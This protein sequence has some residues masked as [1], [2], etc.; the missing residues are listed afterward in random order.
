M[1]YSEKLGY[2]M[3]FFDEYTAI[4]TLDSHEMIVLKQQRLNC[5]VDMNMN[6]Q[7]LVD[8]VDTMYR[9][10][11]GIWKH[12]PHIALIQGLYKMCGDP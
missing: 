1:S 2:V 7:G 3:G 5:V 12:P 9:N 4:S 6:S 10:D 8:L 11:V